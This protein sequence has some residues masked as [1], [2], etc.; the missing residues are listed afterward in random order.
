LSTLDICPLLEQSFVMA[1]GLDPSLFGQTDHE[2]YL[3][4]ASDAGQENGMIATWLMPATLVPDRPRLVAAISVANVTHR[5]I[6]KSRRFCVQLLA[7]DQLDL[8]PRFG[9]FSAR[10][11]DKLAGLDLGR[12]PAGLPLIQGIC[13]YADCAVVDQ[14]ESGDRTVFL[15][16]MTFQDYVNNKAPLRKRAAFSRLPAKTVMAL[17]EKRLQDGERDAKLI[18]RFRT[19]DGVKHDDG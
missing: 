9:L 17:L 12:S 1:T 16:D 8:V 11:R 19:T 2:I 5:M 6:D 4:T 15:A 13:A 18:K 14:M 3:I 7:E 10:E